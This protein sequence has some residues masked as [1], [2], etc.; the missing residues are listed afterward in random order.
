MA[1]A[2]STRDRIG[3]AT[4]EITDSCGASTGVEGV[5]VELPGEGVAA[6]ASLDVVDVYQEAKERLVG[7][8]DCQT[9]RDVER[10]ISNRNF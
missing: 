9:E 6:G 10:E 1:A 8:C 5:A 3:P 2:S 4:V 7:R